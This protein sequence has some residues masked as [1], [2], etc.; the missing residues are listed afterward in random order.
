MREFVR[1]FMLNVFTGLGIATVVCVIPAGIGLG[2]AKLA[3]WYPI[4]KDITLWTIGVCGSI[5][6]LWAVGGVFREKP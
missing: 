6:L 2:L 1:E 5:V 3:E 4:M